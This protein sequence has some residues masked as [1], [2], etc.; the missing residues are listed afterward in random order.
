MKTIYLNR[1]ILLSLSLLLAVQFLSGCQP[2]QKIPK[3]PFSLDS[4]ATLYAQAKLRETVSMPD[5]LKQESLTILLNAH[6]I[7]KDSLQT[8]LNYFKKSP[9]AW[10]LLYQKVEALTHPQKKS[11]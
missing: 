8:I 11:R 4:L 7:T 9:E 10:A 6:S 1:A 3:I 5:S 2:Q